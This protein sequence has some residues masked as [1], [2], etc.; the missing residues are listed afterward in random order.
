M[1]RQEKQQV[2]DAMRASF[3]DSRASFLV[4]VQGLSVSGVQKLRKKVRAEGGQ[5]NVVK[6][7]LLEKAVEG[8]AGVQD[9]RPHF[10]N[11]IAVVFAF[12]EFTPVARAIND[13]AK[14]QENLKIV[15]GYFEGHVAD[16]ARVKYVAT[17][18]SRDQL[19]AQVCGGLK[20]TITKLAYAIKMASEK[21][22]PAAE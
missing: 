21:Q 2:I 5:V 9:L 14:E 18:P 11:Q 7:T 6:N 22:Q 3:S 8:I 16:A 12:K 17:L 4:G 20:A 10:Q 15:A 13:V 19:L 1:N